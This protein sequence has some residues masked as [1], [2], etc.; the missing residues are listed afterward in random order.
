MI[1]T[2]TMTQES[3]EAEQRVTHS[4]AFG[5]MDR[6]LRKP[7]AEEVFRAGNAALDQVCSQA[8]DLGWL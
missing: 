1:I 8:T 7:T 3:G 4:R 6:A 5:P 2:V